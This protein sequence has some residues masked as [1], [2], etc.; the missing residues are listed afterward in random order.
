LVRNEAK[1]R[2]KRLAIPTR[3]IKAKMVPNMCPPFSNKKHIFQ[4]YPLEQGSGEGVL[5]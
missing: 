2:M 4:N 3:T 1:V 5:V